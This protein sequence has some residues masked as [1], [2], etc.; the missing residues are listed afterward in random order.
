[1][2]TPTMPGEPT[3]VTPTAQETPQNSAQESPI[4]LSN[5]V[6][7][8]NPLQD[9]VMVTPTPLATATPGRVETAIEDLTVST[10]LNEVTFLGI[11]SAEWINLLVSLIYVAVGVFVLIPLV[12]Y[13]LRRVL[14]NVRYGEELLNTI[15]PQVRWFVTT[16]II[17]YAVG[18]VG[19][20]PP[21]VKQWVNQQ[22]LTLYMI[23]VT[24]AAWRVINRVLT[25][26]QRTRLKRNPQAQI[27]WLIVRRAI[28]IVLLII[29]STIVLN[30]YGVSVTLPLVVL[31]LIGF[32]ASIAARDTLT[33]F[34][35]GF[36]ILIDQ[37]FRVGD[38]I[39]IQE[40][41]RWGDVV[42][43]GPRTTR[44]R[45][46]D[47]RLVIVPN[48]QIGRS[49]VVNYTY[50]D[51][52]YRIETRLGIGYGSD[53]EQVRRLIIETVRGVPGVVTEQPIDALFDDFGDSALLFRIRWWSHSY[54]D[55][56]HVR[57]RVHTA[58]YKALNQA[59]IEIPFTTYAVHV[60]DAHLPGQDIT[61]HAEDEER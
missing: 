3:A 49:Q 5:V 26:Y 14:K 43:I 28:Q 15:G 20:I 50:P 36:I 57:D 32:S 30:N 56:H 29:A 27:L 45:T 16:F 23:L 12:F 4:S 39:E 48:S 21:S 18:R 22:C 11:E 41:D 52:R 1:M 10:R 61:E 58:L 8:A 51:T 54:T 34:L 55:T 59:A 2:S 42:E 6:D 44:I 37:P 9:V 46:L 47:N 60:T 33:D 53:V 19:V 38:R 25:F 40:I 17:Q 13:T 24:I 31:A 7:I 35:D